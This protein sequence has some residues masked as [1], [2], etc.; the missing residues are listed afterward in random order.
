MYIA[1]EHMSMRL[2]QVAVGIEPAAEVMMAFETWVRPTAFVTPFS[3][4][5]V[6]IAGPTFC[7]DDN[8]SA[9]VH[10]C[11]HMLVNPA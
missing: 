5:A 7:Y 4:S 1:T 8:V 9:Y 3:L 11:G 2:L 6:F 10:S